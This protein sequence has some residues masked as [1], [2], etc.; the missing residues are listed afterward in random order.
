M[1]MVGAPEAPVRRRPMREVSEKNGTL[2]VMSGTTTLAKVPVTPQLKQSIAMIWRAYKTYQSAGGKESIQAWLKPQ[3][4]K[5]LIERDT[6]QNQ[7]GKSKSATAEVPY[8]D[9]I[10]LGT[11]IGIIAEAVI[12]PTPFGLIVGIAIDIATEGGG[13]SGEPGGEGDGSYGDHPGGGGIE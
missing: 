8:S 10:G 5:A 7:I 3:L 1:V 2:H 6:T 9:D 4:E 11:L 13:G 12:A